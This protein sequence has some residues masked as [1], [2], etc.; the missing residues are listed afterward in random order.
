MGVILNPYGEGLSG[1][2]CLGDR[3]FKLPSGTTSEYGRYVKSPGDPVTGTTV[4]NL[5]IKPVKQM[6]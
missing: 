3:T 4:Q 6:K 1:Q 5:K 2:S